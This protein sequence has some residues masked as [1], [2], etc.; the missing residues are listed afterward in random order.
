M[1]TDL[2]RDDGLVDMLSRVRRTIRDYLRTKHRVEDANQHPIA[3]ILAAR[4]VADA[5]RQDMLSH[6][7]R[8]RGAGVPWRDLAEPLGV[9]QSDTWVDPP[10]EAFRLV[11]GP[12]PMPYDPIYATWSCASCE[13]VITD[14]GPLAG[15]PTD[16][17]KG[18]R[19][20][21]RRYANEI[22]AYEART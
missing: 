2:P 11:A 5:A 17:E 10:G 19:D 13:Q 20:D 9:D 18:H 1:T 4:A 15:H 8:A 16:A 22:A 3:A 14:S 7:R 21:C 6:A 12:P